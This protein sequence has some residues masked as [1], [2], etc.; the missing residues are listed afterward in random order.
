MW[1]LHRSRNF[2]IEPNGSVHN[3]S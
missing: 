2:K 3:F 1:P